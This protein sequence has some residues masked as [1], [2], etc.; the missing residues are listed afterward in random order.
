MFICKNCGKFLSGE[1]TKWCSKECQN[2]ARRKVF[3]CKICGCE[4]SG[5]LQVMY[6]ENCTCSKKLTQ[7]EIGSKR[8]QLLIEKCGGKCKIC[9]YNKCQRSLS[10]HH[11]DRA[12]KKFSLD[13]RNL[14][15]R[16]WSSILKELEKCDM[17][18]MN[19]HFEIEDDI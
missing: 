9:G 16:S 5:R 18:C 8:K 11:R 3:N 10:F 17:V 2:L 1:R 14:A 7:K 6:C 13:C 12:T 4:L 15:N 19:C